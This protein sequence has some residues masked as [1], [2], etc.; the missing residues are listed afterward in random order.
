M[1]VHPNIAVAGRVPTPLVIEAELAL[2]IADA[3]GG[4]KTS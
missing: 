2:Y 4:D 1:L 3:F